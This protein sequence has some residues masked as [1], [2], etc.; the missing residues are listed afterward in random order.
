M[1][2]AISNVQCTVYWGPPTD[3]ARRERENKSGSTPAAF[4][5][6]CL[7]LSALYQIMAVKI[8]KRWGA[9]ISPSQTAIYHALHYFVEWRSPASL[10]Q[11]INQARVVIFSWKR[12]DPQG[13]G[14]YAFL[15]PQYS[16]SVQVPLRREFKKSNDDLLRRAP[17]ITQ[18]S[19]GKE[20][21]EES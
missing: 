10:C 6:Q 1:I 2:G 14:A 13:L 7:L 3:G 9:Q 12:H 18:S 5:G 21:E 15:H 17:S 20:G 16:S 8:C 19:K 11:F 4:T